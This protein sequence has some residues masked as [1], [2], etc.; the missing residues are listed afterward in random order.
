MIAVDEST[1]KARVAISAT[2][3][4]GVVEVTESTTGPPLGKL[5][6]NFRDGNH[7]ISITTV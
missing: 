3:Q 6:L 7:L 1:Q 5:V 4:V 2:E